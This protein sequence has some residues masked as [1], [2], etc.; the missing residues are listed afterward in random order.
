MYIDLH[1]EIQEDGQTIRLKDVLNPVDR[2][3][4]TAPRFPSD[5]PRTAPEPPRFATKFFDEFSGKQRTLKS[6]W[7]NAKPKATKS[8]VKAESPSLLSPS[9]SQTP[10]TPGQTPPIEDVQ[11]SS[12]LGIARA[13]FSSLDSATAPA[14]PA[15]RSSSRA[16]T[17]ATDPSQ[18]RPAAIDLTADEEPRKRTI[19]ERSKSA[20]VKKTA[21]G[22]MKLASFFSQPAPKAKVAESPLRDP[23]EHQRTELAFANASAPAVGAEEMPDTERDALIAIAMAEEDDQREK[24]RAAQKEKAAPVWSEIFA[25]K[26]PPKCKVHARPCKD[27]SEFAPVADADGRSRQARL[28]QG[29]TI[30]AVL[31]ASRPRI[32]HGPL[33]AAAGTGQR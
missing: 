31:S 21:N 5:V 2:P 26:I 8:E 30:L 25:K 14:K 3:E 6:L 15:A 13:A 28:Q 23:A 11:P 9:P 4:S 17:S 20:T 33:E 12:T 1:D 18:K 7:A 16:T 24:K 10:D 22:Q 19:V 32:R 27:F 29:Q